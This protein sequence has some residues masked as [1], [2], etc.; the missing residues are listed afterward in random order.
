MQV[1][2]MLVI[3]Q[4]FIETLQDISQEASELQEPIKHT[5][6]FEIIDRHIKEIEDESNRVLGC[7]D[8]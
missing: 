4:D 6:V 8:G 7:K 5:D 1:Y 3:Q 2:E